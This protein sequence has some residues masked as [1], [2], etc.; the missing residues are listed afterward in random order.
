[1]SA[2]DPLKG[3]FDDFI[4]RMSIPCCPRMGSCWPLHKI[5]RKV[6]ANWEKRDDR[7]GMG[8]RVQ[9]GNAV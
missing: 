2:G 3:V 9:E 4:H 6:R 8:A 5:V 1:M 7:G